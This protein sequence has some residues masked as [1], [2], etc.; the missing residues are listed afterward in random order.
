MEKDNPL[1]VLLERVICNMP[2]SLLCKHISSRESDDS[3]HAVLSSPDWL[4][5]K[6]AYRLLLHKLMAIAAIS[7]DGMTLS[8]QCPIGK[9]LILKLLC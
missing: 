2:S 3:V 9:S 5:Q 1:S 7:D 6:S 4:L 8:S